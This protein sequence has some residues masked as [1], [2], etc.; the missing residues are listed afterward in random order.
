MMDSG[1]YIL[2]E[3]L[4]RFESEFASYCDATHGAGCGSGLDALRLILDGYGIK[5]GDEVLV[6][7]RPTRGWVGVLPRS[8]PISWPIRS[9]LPL[10]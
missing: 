3:E 2:G 10:G 1:C 5:S 8:G 9:I 6:P 7:A 4:A